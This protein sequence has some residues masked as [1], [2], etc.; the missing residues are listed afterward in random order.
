MADLTITAASVLQGSNASVVHGRAGATITQGQMVYLEAASGKYKLADA[1]GATTE[2]KTPVGVA[3]NSA[4][5][6]QP[7]AIQVRGD[8]T[9]GA[10]LTLN[11]RYYLSSTPGGIEPEADLSAGEL[12]TLVGIATSTT[13]LR[14]IMATAG[15]VP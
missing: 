15:A 7:L 4:S 9:I 12:C 1:D 2:I 10:T 8:I 13:V 11:A 14:L 6:G 3:L 5:D